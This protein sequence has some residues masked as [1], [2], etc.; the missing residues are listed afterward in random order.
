MT[1]LREKVIIIVYTSVYT[2][3]EVMDSKGRIAV[4]I[5]QISSNTE[6]GFIDSI[7]TKACE[8]GYDTII[9]SGV[10]NYVDQHLDLSYSKGQTNIYDLIIHGDFD[11]FIFDANAFCSAK[12]RSSII[13]M[14]RRRDIPCVAVNYQQPYFSVISAD[15]EIQLYLSATHLIKEHGCRKLF[16]IGGHKGDIPS[17]KRIDGFRR[18]MAESGLSCDENCIFY[19]DYWR[20][21]PHKIAL[22][23]VKGTIGKP[24]G[25]VCGSDIMAVELVRTLTENGI[26][27]PEDIKVTGCDGSAVSQSEM[28]TLTTVS[29]QERRNGILAVNK[30]LELMGNVVS[31]ADTPPELVIGESCGCEYICRSKSLSDIREYTGTV[32]RILE[33]RKTNSHGEMIRRMSE[34]K[35]IYDVIGTFL[36]CCYMI[37]T[38]VK[39]ELCLC[40]DWC[41]DLDDPSVYRRGGLSDNM[42]LAIE[43]C[44]EGGDKM[45][46]FQTKDIFPSL[47][48]PHEPRLTVVT[49]L[50]YKGQ[51]FGYVAFTYRKAVHIVLDE[52]YTNWCDAAASG[53]NTIQNR[54]Y[55][56]HVNKRIESL[57]EF[58]P[59]LGIYNKRGLI[60]KLMNMLA[61][62]SNSQLS[63]TLLSYIK[64]ERVHYSVPPVNTIVNAIR[65]CDNTSVLA[66]IGD[67]IIACVSAAEAEIGEGED[68]A[69]RISESVKS[70]YKGSVEIK[71]E[72]LAAVSCM[73]S[74]SD[75]FGIDSVISS[76]SDTLRGKMISLSSGVFSYKD[77]F[78]SLREDIFRHPEKDW[79]I[80]S[81][82]RSM[83]LSKS[84]FHRIY[85]ELFDTSCKDDIITSRMKKVKWMLEN[86]ALSA[87]QIS[88]QCGYS[89]YSHFIRQFT[90]RTG[91]SPSAYRKAH[92]Q[93][94]N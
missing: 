2:G 29:G 28:I 90:N 33:Q 8:Y 77:R 76:L 34:C 24:D 64:E 22:D 26:K 35:D 67:D 71:K 93:K 83:G 66:S 55:K 13:D 20:D 70:S 44:Y 65:I 59:V 32:F 1:Y 94:S 37:P 72:R 12:L 17:E 48:K 6:T 87:L 23:I 54:M 85:K 62:N 11:G 5:P 30:L 52:F 81:V 84:H 50:H 51:I 46:R 58:A 27:V 56:D 25:I 21:I 73:V 3:G 47:N 41:R 31:D 60:N 91:M 86:T 79:N 38:G 82:T 92:G 43:A 42:L 74:R 36:G 69:Q 68:L 49:S 16:C 19:G 40:D 57:S 7:H 9:I 18:A 80:E 61:D 45:V 88:E 78:S 89:N 53:L 4:I 10:I 39:A 14:L 15:E 63:L 75:I